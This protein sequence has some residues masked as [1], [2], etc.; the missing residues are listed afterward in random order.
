MALLKK[1]EGTEMSRQTMSFHAQN[2]TYIVPNV[3]SGKIEMDINA[4]HIDMDTV[5]ILGDIS[6]T[7][8]S[9]TTTGLA[10]Y[11]GSAW[12]KRMTVSTKNAGLQIGEVMNY[13]NAAARLR[14]EMMGTSQRDASFDA[15]FELADTGALSAG[16]SVAA[17]EFSHKP[18]QHI[19]ALDE[20]LPVSYFNGL[21]LNIDFETPSN[22]V[23]Q[24]AGSAPVYTISNLRVVC[25]VVRLKP[26]TEAMVAKAVQ[27]GKMLVDYSQKQVSVSS[28]STATSQRFDFGTMNG[29]V[30]SLQGYMVKS[31]D[32][33]GADEDFL[34][35]FSRNN[36]SSYRWKHGENYP[37]TRAT[38]VSAT[39]AAEY[40]SEWYKSQDLE[41]V[42][43]GLYGKTSLTPTVLLASKFVF[44]QKVSRSN[45]PSVLSSE[46]NQNNNKVEL[47]MTFDSAPSVG[48]VYAVVDLDKQFLIGPSK[49]IVNK[50]FA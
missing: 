23:L 48:S 5:R 27:E 12:I 24:S 20:Y 2:S 14:F 17:R 16:D 33:N 3:G 28:V 15:V 13:Y 8:T 45:D 35:T 37:N 18:S 36:L 7:T 25:D 46:R 1:S 43:T 39:R 22:V 26:E 38:G 32:I 21:E 4:G 31:D 41:F 11:A 50:D 40:L 30:K 44:G 47:E 10:K 34:A 9:G 6:A 19:F 49:R 42:N 29:R